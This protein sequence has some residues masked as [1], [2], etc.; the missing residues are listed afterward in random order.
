MFFD[1]S[2]KHVQ[3]LSASMFVL[4]AFTILIGGWHDPHSRAFGITMMAGSIWLVVMSESVLLGKVQNEM[5]RALEDLRKKQASEIQDLLCF[6]KQSRLAVS[7]FE[8]LDGA[9][10]LCE[11]IE[12]PS[13]VLGQNQQIIKANQK[14]HDLLGW[15]KNDL[16]GKPAHAINN[17]VVM[18]KIGEICALPENVDK[19]AITTQYIYVHKSG[20]RIYGQ[21]D[22]YTIGETEGFLVT[23]HPSDS[24][25]IS[26]EEIRKIV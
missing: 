1:L 21:M 17:I 26:Y 4:G 25:L 8:S 11:A 9:K 10:K 19:K 6:L 20:K 3:I 15:E 13:M 16:N 7:P 18:S 14:M 2:R 22:A 12:H 5:N 23:F 24:C